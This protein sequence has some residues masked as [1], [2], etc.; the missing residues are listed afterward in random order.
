M[1]IAV[2]KKEEYHSLSELLLQENHEEYLQAVAIVLFL[3]YLK[4]LLKKY[5]K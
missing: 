3:S 1:D 5:F 2:Y 4:E